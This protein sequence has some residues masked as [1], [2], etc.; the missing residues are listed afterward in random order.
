ML[1]ISRIGAAALARAAPAAGGTAAAAALVAARP[2]HKNVVDHYENPRNVGSFDKTDANVGTGLVGAPACGDVMKLQIRVDDEGNIV[3][4][5]FK[6]FGCGSAIASSSVATEWI[7]GKSVEEVLEIKNSD[8]AKHLSL[9]PVKLHCSMLAWDA[10]RTPEDAEDASLSRAASLQPYLS[11]INGFYRDHGAEPVAQGDL[12]GK[13]RKGLAASQVE[14]DPPGVRTD[15]PARLVTRTLRLAETLREELGPTWTRDQHPR[16]LLFRAAMAVVA[17]YVF[18]ARGKAGVACQTGDLTVTADVYNPPVGSDPGRA[19]SI[20]D[21][22][23]RSTVGWLQLVAHMLEEHPPLGFVWTSHSLRKGTATAAYAIGV[24]LKKI[25]HFGGWAELS[26]VVLD[27]INPTALPCAASWQ[28]YGWLT[29]WGTQP[30]NPAGTPAPEGGEQGAREPLPAELDAPDDELEYVDFAYYGRVIPPGLERPP[31]DVDE[32]RL[33]TLTDDTTRALA[34]KRSQTA[35]DEYMHLGC[36]AFFSSCANEAMRGAL[37]SL[38]TESATPA[39]KAASL[40]E[41]RACY[42]THLA[43]EEATR[44]RLGYLQ[45]AKNGPTATEAD[46]VF[47]ELAHAKFCTPRR[48]AVSGQLDQLR[49]AFDD[50]TL[51]ISLSAAGNA[52]A[53]AAF[54][55]ATPDKP[56]PTESAERRKQREQAAAARKAA[57]TAT[58]SDKAKAKVTK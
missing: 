46:R 15:V 32:P 4:S 55:K 58:A 6:T 45:L 42:R 35:Y 40:A 22:C 28:L 20:V 36:Y 3:D 49:R 53:A 38:S 37:E 29:H 51:E 25:K 12:I 39:S 23:H 14:P 5:C 7:K 21:I 19:G 50:K 16:I 52:R 47:A 8:I 34:E 10:I 17:M 18:Y 2:Y 24:V 27:Y 44:S 30:A 57:A 33:W 48:I 11:A 43:T 26:S 9:P 41:L 54:A 13:M 1:T 56:A 31:R